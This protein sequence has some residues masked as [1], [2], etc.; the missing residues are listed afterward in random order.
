MR[1]TTVHD[2]R[3]KSQH[4]TVFIRPILFIII[5]LILYSRIHAN[6][7]SEAFLFLY[8]NHEPNEILANDFSI[9]R[10]TSQQNRFIQISSR[11]VCESTKVPFD[12]IRFHRIMQ[13]AKG[14]NI[15]LREPICRKPCANSSFSRNDNNEIHKIRART[16]DKT[17]H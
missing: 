12:F 11:F 5:I 4:D 13:N 2:R 8:A 16:N 9:D 15:K 17:E 6:A 1:G 3:R 14:L 7:E 10:S